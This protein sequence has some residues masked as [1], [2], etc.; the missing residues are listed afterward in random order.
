MASTVT[1]GDKLRSYLISDGVVSSRVGNAVYGGEA[2]ENISTTD[3]PFVRFQRIA[4]RHKNTHS[5]VSEWRAA[6][7]QFDCVAPTR[8]EAELLGEDVVA[9]TTG[10]RGETGI[11]A[12]LVQ[13][14]RENVR[15]EEVDGWQFQVDLDIQYDERITTT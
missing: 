3:M 14:T 7:H 4:T 2:P 13:D 15:D 1:I 8:N 9:T 11:E 12:V 10:L 6:S 5:G